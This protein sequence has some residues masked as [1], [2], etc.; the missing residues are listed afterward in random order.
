MPA[1]PSENASAR[2]APKAANESTA[3]AKLLP[4]T[5]P[6]QT[7]PAKQIIRDTAKDVKYSIIVATGRDDKANIQTA[8]AITRAAGHND[9][10]L[11]TLLLKKIPRCP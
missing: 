2:C 9:N 6:A 1:A 5:P 8:M 7:E 4:N 3:H 11:A 10:N